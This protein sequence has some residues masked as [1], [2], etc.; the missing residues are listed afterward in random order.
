MKFSLQLEKEQIMAWLFS[1]WY[2]CQQHQSGNQWL[3]NHD[4]KYSGID[5]L[6][7]TGGSECVMDAED[8]EGEWHERE[9][10]E[11]R[12]R[13]IKIN[14]QVSSE[15]SKSEMKSTERVKENV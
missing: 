6:D 8:K 9:S 14:G 12:E 11:K 13:E 7:P 1:T 2:V 3:L 4:V 15:E 10:R 5:S